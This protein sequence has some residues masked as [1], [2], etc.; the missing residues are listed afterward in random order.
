M[1]GEL[2]ELSRFEN[3]WCKLSGLTTEADHAKWTP[4]DLRPY[5]DHVVDSFG[6]ERVMFGGDW[7]VSIQA[8]QYPRWT[9]ILDEVLAGVAEGNRAKF[10]R[11]NAMRV[12]TRPT[13]QPK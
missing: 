7:P 8:I 9:E 2:R 1:A 4:A 5:I 10:W 13:I 3:V 11:E 6:F 12:Y